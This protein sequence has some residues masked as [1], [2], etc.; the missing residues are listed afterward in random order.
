MVKRIAITAMVLLAA[1]AVAS[2][3]PKNSTP[4]D[5]HFLN[6]S[7]SDVSLTVDG[8]PAVDCK[9]GGMCDFKVTRGKHAFHAKLAKGGESSGDFT[10][11]AGFKMVCVSVYPNKKMDFSDC[12]Q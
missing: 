7:G 8:K 9:D 4:I 3:T 10:I 1:F 11:P 5:G 2:D 6:S 12:G